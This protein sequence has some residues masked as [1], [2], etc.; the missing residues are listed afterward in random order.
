[1][2]F[3]GEKYNEENLK[4]HESILFRHCAAQKS[5]FDLLC[6]DDGAELL[7]GAAGGRQL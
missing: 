2:L 1:M 7:Y 5:R 6:G 3:Y 4:Q